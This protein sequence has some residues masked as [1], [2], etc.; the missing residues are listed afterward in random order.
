M[1][2]EGVAALGALRHIRGMIRFPAFLCLVLVFSSAALAQSPG[3]KK[4]PASSP[5]PAAP[6]PAVQDVLPDTAE[7]LIAERKDLVVI[8]VRTVEEYNM[9]HLAGAKNASFIDLEFEE[10]IAPFEGKPVLVH[11]TS[12]NRS[13]RAVQK[14]KM[15]GK[16]P[17]IYHLIG[18]I[19]A[20]QAAGKPV[21][22]TV[23]PG[24]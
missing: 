12:G 3:D 7:K 15:S 9:S 18:G 23:S 19:T 14:M 2:W 1:G 21:V 17:E 5:A 6:K 22:K 13:L 10:Q 4:K 20:W 24:R 16:F 8:D 11:C